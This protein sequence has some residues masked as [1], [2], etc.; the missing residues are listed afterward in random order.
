MKKK[1]KERKKKEE[2]NSFFD[3]MEMASKLHS[4]SES[5]FDS[6]DSQSSSPPLKLARLEQ[7][8]QVKN[9]ELENN[10]DSTN[11]DTSSPQGSTGADSGI[12]SI[13]SPSD[14]LENENDPRVGANKSSTTAD[15]LNSVRS[16]ARV[17]HLKM[18]VDQQQ[19]RSKETSS[20]TSSDL[21]I[22]SN[23]EPKLKR[24]WE[25]WSS[26]DKAIFFEAL[27]ECGKNFD[28]IQ[29]YFGKKN[30]K[31]KNKEQI[32]TFYYRTWHKI[33]KYVDLSETQ[34]GSLHNDL[35]KSS[36]EIYG[37]INFGELRKRLGSQL[38]D[39][40]GMK[41]RELIF[42]GHTNV[43][44]KGK[45]Y[46]LRTP[47]CAALKKLSASSEGNVLDLHPMTGCPT[48][49]PSKLVLNLTP[50]TSCD[51]DLVHRLSQ[52]NPHVSLSLRPGRSLASVMGKK[53]YN[54]KY[55]GIFCIYY[56]RM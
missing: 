54:L 26:E 39:K 49:V 40:T 36:I 8:Y 41:L 50:S 28:A 15:D 30:R 10:Q 16:S 4:E 44:I 52:A 21:N 32:R 1:K 23:F 37:L 20:S 46:R 9:S 12:S 48:T 51:F 34:T 35:K 18:K 42:K 5:G 53:S 55:S 24:A 43:R 2:R 17:H 38:D 27:N 13:T 7:P 31:N 14:E 3:N 22:E 56:L 47:T 45:T 29:V 6:T 33:C 11:I 19:Q 25:Q